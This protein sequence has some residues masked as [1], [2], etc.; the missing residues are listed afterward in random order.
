M[1]WLW[2]IGFRKAFLIYIVVDLICIGPLGMCVPFFSILLGFPV[3]WY[4]TKRLYTPDLNV[5]ILLRGIFKYT[6]LHQVLLLYS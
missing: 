1:D 3:G 6:C 4:L 2:S 5:K